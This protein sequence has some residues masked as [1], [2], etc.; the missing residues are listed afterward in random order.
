MLREREGSVAV[1][2]EERRELETKVW[3]ADEL[4]EKVVRREKHRRPFVGASSL[5]YPISI[6]QYPNIAAPT[7]TT[8]TTT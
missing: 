4:R 5:D 2:K 6:R 1:L 8:P 7:T 3:V